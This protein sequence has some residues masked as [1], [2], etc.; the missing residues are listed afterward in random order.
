MLKLEPRAGMNEV[1][2]LFVAWS[3]FLV[4][5]AVTPDKAI[6]WEANFVRGKQSATTPDYALEIWDYRQRILSSRTVWPDSWRTDSKWRVHD[7]FR[8]CKVVNGPAGLLLRQ[9]A[10]D[11]GGADLPGV[12]C[13]LCPDYLSLTEKPQ[14]LNPRG[15]T[16]STDPN[17][18]WHCPQ[19]PFE[20]QRE[21][22]G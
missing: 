19:G 17:G 11:V 12:Y 4:F 16:W 18:M 3:L 6:G 14:S 15:C 5:G 10:L 22:A 9:S 1:L 2:S 8:S 13:V 21:V 20:A 7:A